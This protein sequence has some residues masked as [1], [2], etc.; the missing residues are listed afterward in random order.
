MFDHIE[1]SVVKN[2]FQMENCRSTDLQILVDIL[3]KTCP[4]GVELS[5]HEH[6]EEHYESR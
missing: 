3:R 4:E 2:P 1:K 5:I 6:Q